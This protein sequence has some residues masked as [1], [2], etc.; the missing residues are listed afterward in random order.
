MGPLGIGIGLGLT[1]VFVDDAPDQTLGL[2][3]LSTMNYF[4]AVLGTA[5]LVP[6]FI[7]FREKPPLPPR[8]ANNANCNF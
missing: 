7:L 8:Y 5:L 3:Q 4:Y 6:T 2:Q 1:Q